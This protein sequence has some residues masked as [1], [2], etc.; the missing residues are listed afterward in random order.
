MIQIAHLDAVG[1]QHPVPLPV[2]SIGQNDLALGA[3]GHSVQL[4]SAQDLVTNAQVELVGVRL[5]EGVRLPERHVPILP[6][7]T[8]ALGIRQEFGRPR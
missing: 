1:E 7:T 4:D 3:G 5:G 6:D 2:E 8:A